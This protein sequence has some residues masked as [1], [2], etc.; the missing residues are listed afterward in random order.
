MIS[1]SLAA[2]RPTARRRDWRAPAR[3]ARPAAGAGTE[4][5]AREPV[6]PAAFR[7]CHEDR[8]RRGRTAEPG[9]ESGDRPGVAEAAEDAVHAAQRRIEKEILQVERGNQGLAGMRLRGAEAGAAGHEPMGAIVNGY[10]IQDGAQDAP[11]D[12]L[13]PGLGQFDQPRRT[14]PLG[15]EGIGVVLEERDGGA[16]ML[17]SGIREPLEVTDREFQARPRTRRASP[18]GGCRV[19][20]IVA[21]G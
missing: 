9:Q 7:Q 10:A 15:R 17:V 3:S 2:G 18:A 5:L 6:V 11:L 8:E 14:E 4:D 1:P 19:P 20:E 16:P 12:G 13:E 21:P